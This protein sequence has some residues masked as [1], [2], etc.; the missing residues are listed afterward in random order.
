MRFL[1]VALSCAACVTSPPDP[2]SQGERALL[3]GDLLTALS[4]FDRVPVDHLHYPEARAAAVG[5]EHRMRKSQELLLEGLLL[6]TEWR[7][8]EAVAAFQRARSVW[9]SQPCAGELIQATQARMRLFENGKGAIGRT[10]TMLPGAA[11]DVAAAPPNQE[12][13]IAPPPGATPGVEVQ[14]A[15]VDKPAEITP[16]RPGTESPTADDLGEDQVGNRLATIEAMLG[17][18]RFDDAVSDLLGLYRQRPEDLRVR[19][20]LARVLHQRALLRYGQGS[21]VSA[22]TDWQRVVELDPSAE[23]ARRLLQLAQRE[24]AS[25]DR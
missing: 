24:Q 20:R 23:D 3:R 21:V 22:I 7:D 4:A 5:V 14:F 17:R 6:R 13:A 19:L 9:P 10:R 18:G 12:K 25:R 11:A 16:P 2:Y 15:P 8:D 1:V